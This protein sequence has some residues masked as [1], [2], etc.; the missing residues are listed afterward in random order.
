MVARKTIQKFEKCRNLF[1]ERWAIGGVRADYKTC[2][3]GEKSCG[4]GV[5]AN[6]LVRG[7]CKS[8]ERTK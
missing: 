3:N 4:L 1:V 7:G 8:P 5:K 2:E 6:T